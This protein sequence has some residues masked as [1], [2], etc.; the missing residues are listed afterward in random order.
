MGWIEII[1]F[2]ACAA[3][4]GLCWWQ[5]RRA[6][7]ELDS[8]AGDLQELHA[9]AAEVDAALTQY[10]RQAAAWPPAPLRANGHEKQQQGEAWCP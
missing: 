2:A 7:R 1:A 9:R 10:E 6:V 8:V 5:W 3:W 4:G